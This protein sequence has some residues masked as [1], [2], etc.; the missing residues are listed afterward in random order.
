MWIKTKHHPSGITPLLTAKQTPLL[1]S[2][3]L[4]RL[5]KKGR[6][7]VKRAEA[8][9]EELRK[10]DMP[11][12]KRPNPKELEK[13]IS[14]GVQQ[15]IKNLSSN[16]ILLIGDEKKALNVAYFIQYA[17]NKEYFFN[18]ECD[19]CTP[20]DIEI[21]KEAIITRI[22]K[23]SNT[24]I[25]ESVAVF[26]Y[27]D[28]GLTLFLG[29]ARLTDDPL[30]DD[31]LSH[32]KTLKKWGAY[33]DEDY[34]AKHNAILIVH[35]NRTDIPEHVKTEFEVIDLTK[36]AEY[37]KDIEKQE[38]VKYD[39]DRYV[40]FTNEKH[41]PLTEDKKILIK[42]LFEGRKHIDLLCEKIAESKGKNKLKYSKGNCRKL[43]TETN[44]LIEKE[45]GIKKFV[46]NEKNKSGFYHLTPKPKEGIFQGNIEVIQR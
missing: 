7:K 14:K 30:T 13:S 37:G 27:S 39:K 44:K 2:E 16:Y 22:V 4:L 35:T 26:R 42:Y 31:F 12:V 19:Y 1:T 38:S 43:R 28:L 23:P 10:K 21:E 29:N 46:R 24:R 15:E 5:K 6:E 33:R 9:E 45:F 8:E 36:Q 34:L 40:L 18:C 17:R 3:E 41:L 32:I 20:K 11:E 25:L